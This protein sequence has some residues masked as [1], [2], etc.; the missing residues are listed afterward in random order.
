MHWVQAQVGYTFN[1]NA[2]ALAKTVTNRQFVD[3]EVGLT[4]RQIKKDLFGRAMSKWQEKWNNSVTG[5]VTYKSFPGV[6]TRRLQG[7]FYV[8]QVLT[9]HGTFGD[10][11]A[12]FFQKDSTCF[13][14]VSDNMN[15]MQYRCTLWQQL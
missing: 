11:Q 4:C 1:E 10:Y 2:D 6:G 12:R 13:C 5:R 8:N 14:G 9:G 15:H 3:V 7:S